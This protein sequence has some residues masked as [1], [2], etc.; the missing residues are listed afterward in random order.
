MKLN[1]TLILILLVTLV[2]LTGMAWTAGDEKPVCPRTGDPV[3]CTADGPHG[4]RGMADPHHRPDRMAEALDLTD[5]QRDAMREIMNTAREATR[6]RKEAALADIL[7]PEQLDRLEEIKAREGAPGD[8]ERPD[9]AGRKGRQGS[10]GQ[11]GGKDQRGGDRGDTAARRL[12]QMTANLD[13]TPEQQEQIRR[14]LE[15]SA[16]PQRSEIR[17]RIREVLTPE[18][19]EKMDQ[20]QSRRQ[21]TTPD[22]GRDMNQGRRGQ[23][24]GRNP[25]GRGPAGDEPGL[26]PQLARQLNLTAE[27]RTAVRELMTEIDE[28]QQE[29]TRSQIE[30]L[31]TPEQRDK[32]EQLHQN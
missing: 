17:D 15:D 12:E 1:G 3:S 27:Q 10:K 19:Q 22:Q 21:G 8:M 11:K 28:Q 9:R 23:G 18:Q 30:E 6:L 2:A 31:L 14:I 32:L 13:L 20:Q 4:P 5:Q 24:Q 25:Q 26:G 29:Q 16:P 7:T